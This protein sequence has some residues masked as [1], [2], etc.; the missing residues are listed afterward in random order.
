MV[1]LGIVCYSKFSI[2]RECLRRVEVLKP[3]GAVD[4]FRNLDGV[5]HFNDN[6]SVWIF[7]DEVELERVPLQFQRNSVGENSYE[8]DIR[9]L[10]IVENIEE[11]AHFEKGLSTN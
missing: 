8:N 6:E 7:A 4:F 11:P 3:R 5:N 1:L 2:Y 10:S 9:S